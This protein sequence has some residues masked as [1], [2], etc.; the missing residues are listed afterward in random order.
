M[1]ATSPRGR[2]NVIHSEPSD[3][4]RRMSPATSSIDPSKAPR[5]LPFGVSVKRQHVSRCDADGPSGLAGHLTDHSRCPSRG[6]RGS[7]RGDARRRRAARRAGARVRR[8]CRAGHPPRWAGAASDEGCGAKVAS[9]KVRYL[10]EKL[11]LSAL[12]AALITRRYSSVCAPR[13]TERQPQVAELLLIPAD[14][15]AEDETAV[16]RLDRPWPPPWPSR[17]DCD[18]ARRPRS[19]P[20]GL[21]ARG[22]R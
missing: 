17:A 4:A 14:A 12:H 13:W 20:R 1:P 7:A 18:T 2:S 15:D 10:P 9:E 5:P 19:R 6:R 11:G 21:A 16:A 3:R 8:A 22:L